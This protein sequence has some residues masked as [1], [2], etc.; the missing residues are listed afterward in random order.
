VKDQ[1]QEIQNT[2]ANNND[3]TQWLHDSINKP[4]RHTSTHGQT[5]SYTSFI[6][7][8]RH[9][10]LYCPSKARPIT[11][12]AEADECRIPH[13]YRSAHSTPSISFHVLIRS[14]SQEMTKESD[15]SLRLILWHHVS[16][17][18][19]GKEGESIGSIIIRDEP[20]SPII[21]SS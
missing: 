14:T 3:N 19:D 15:G 7:I 4:L 12:T 17:M 5:H 21:S 10:H 6:S 16:C 13:K 2:T 20:S 8:S 11:P 18:L 9:K 1:L